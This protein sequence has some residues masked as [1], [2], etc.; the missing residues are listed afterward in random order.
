MLEHINKKQKTTPS[1][2]DAVDM[3]MMSHAKTIKTFSARRQAI[4]KKQISDIIGNLEI[5]QIEENEYNRSH[6]RTMLSQPSMSYYP[7]NYD[8]IINLST[9]NDNNNL[10]N[11]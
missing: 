7:L 11:S 8:N 6:D 9:E 5:E 2:L 1:A 3:L 10:Q 4:A